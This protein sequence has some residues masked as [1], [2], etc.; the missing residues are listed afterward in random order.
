MVDFG[1]IVVA[2]LNGLANGMLLLLAAVG[3]TLIF[4]VLGVLNFAHGSLYM[5]G[6][7]F[8][9][10][11]MQ[12]SILPG[13][14]QE[15]FWLSAIVAIVC[16]S[17][18][19]GL[20]EKFIIRRIY[21]YTHEFQLLL[22]FALVLIIDYG[23]RIVYGAQPKLVAVPPALDFSFNILGRQYPAYNAFILLVGIIVIVA[24]WAMFTYTR[25]GKKTRAAAQDRE[26]A[27]AHGINVYQIFTVVFILGSALAALGGVLAAPYQSITPAMGEHIIVDSFIIVIIGGLGSFPGAL[28][29]A[30]L[31]GV[32]DATAFLLMPEIQSYV[33][34]VLMAVV[35]IL[36]PE[37]LLKG[38]ESV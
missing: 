33:P 4:G 5:L 9:I 32:I 22:T 29:G 1:L 36:R 31:I 3:L 23:V 10:L 37:G 7:Y 20:I 26:I 18:V 24:L 38:G 21:E 28:L 17:I 14:L 27:N 34:Y 16:V 2:L 30:L 15:N 13:P 25:F 11:T 8:A 35:L 12:T 6:A 19:G